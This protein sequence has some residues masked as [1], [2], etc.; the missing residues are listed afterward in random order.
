MKASDALKA[1]AAVAFVAVVGGIIATQ[2]GGPDNVRPVSAPGVGGA[3]KRRVTVPWKDKPPVERIKCLR[4]Y[5]RSS[6][7]ARGLF[8]LDLGDGGVGHDYHLVVICGEALDGGA[9]MPDLPPGMEAI[10]YGQEEVPYDGGAQ[11]FAVSQGEPEMPCA[12]SRGLD[13]GCEWR[14]D[15]GGWQRAP[16]HAVLQEGRWRGPGCWGQVCV[17]LAGFPNWPAECPR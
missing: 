2:M 8:D 15:D 3:A 1:G 14:A 5:A 11:L 13:A 9:G 4:T 6:R 10:D 12:C 17:S 16:L 7:E